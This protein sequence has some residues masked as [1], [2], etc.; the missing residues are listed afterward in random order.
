MQRAQYFVVRKDGRWKVS[1]GGKHFGP[2]HTQKHAFRCA[3][4]AAFATE[5][6]AQVLIQGEDNRSRVAWTNGSDPYPP[7]G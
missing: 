1:F 5:G 4:D 6:G 3:V 7:S 2:F